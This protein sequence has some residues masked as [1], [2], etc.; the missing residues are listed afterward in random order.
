MTRPPSALDSATLQAVEVMFGELDE[1][2]ADSSGSLFDAVVRVV[3]RRVPGAGAASLTVLRGGRFTTIAATD[4][5]ARR[6]DA[7]QCALNSGPCVDAI[8]DQTV[9]HCTDLRHDPRWSEYGGARVHRQ[10]GW[11]SVLSHGLSNQLMVDE[12]IAGLNIYADAPHAFDDRA[13]WVGSLLVTHVAL[14]VAAGVSLERARN[15]ERALSSNREIAVAIGVLMT[16]HRITRAAAFNLLRL[17]SQ[18]SNRKMS[19]IATEVADT[20]IPLV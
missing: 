6:A 8:R 3:A 5:R 1:L 14:A 9:Y 16:T 15:L 17:A 4:E 19:D 2:T 20:G 7:L 13:R 12:T 11:A 10:L 18:R